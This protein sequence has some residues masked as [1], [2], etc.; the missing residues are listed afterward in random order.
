MSDAAA[1]GFRAHSGWAVAVAVAGSPSAPTVLARSRLE[2]ADAAIHGS[3]QPYHA[4]R[5]L[6]LPHAETLLG[7]CR[8]RSEALAVDAISAVMTR[9]A[10]SHRLV[11]GGILFGSGGPLPDLE[12]ILRSHALIHTAE[13]KFFREVLVGACERCSLPVVRHTEREVWK[14]GEEAFQLATKTLQER[15]DA[16]GRSLGPPWRQD[17]KLAALTA[18][19]ALSGSH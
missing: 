4:A 2:I 15:I 3:K 1:L 5:E 8:N 18:W 12:A 11:G 10:A 13:G 14:R 17:E 7:H 6:S 9:L 16:L 19:I